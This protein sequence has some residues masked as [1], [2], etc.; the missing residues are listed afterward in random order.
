MASIY[1]TKMPA[2]LA[3]SKGDLVAAILAAGEPVKDYLA[4]KQ[5][6]APNPIAHALGFTDVPG[7]EPQET[8]QAI[9]DAGETVRVANNVLRERFGITVE[10]H[11]GD[12]SGF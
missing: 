3:M 10:F 9:K 1:E 11:Y 12:Y 6:D 7:E 2:Y 5:D 4:E 8:P